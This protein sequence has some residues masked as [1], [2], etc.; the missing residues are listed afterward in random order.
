MRGSLLDPELQRC[1]DGAAV[2]KLAASTQ[3][4]LSSVDLESLLGRLTALRRMPIAGQDLRAFVAKVSALL[5]RLTADEAQRALCAFAALRCRQGALVAWPLVRQ[6]PLPPERLAEAVWA[7][8]AVPSPPKEMLYEAVGL[9]RQLA[10]KLQGL[11]DEACYR[12]VYGTARI[13]TGRGSQELLRQAQLAALRLLRRRPLELRP[14]QLV[15]LCWSL[16]RL[17]C[18]ENKVFEA[19]EQVLPERLDQLQMKERT[20]KASKRLRL[21][22]LEAIRTRN[23]TCDRSWRPSTAS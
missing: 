11:G 20:R 21:A 1:A 4:P 7:A 5:P 19:F 16:A 23:G 12:L 6:A 14:K 8:S 2:L 13:H 9:A 22:L 15:R 3:L 18:Q 17:G 10:P